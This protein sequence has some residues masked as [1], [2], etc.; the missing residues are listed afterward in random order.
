M[1]IPSIS[2]GFNENNLEQPLQRNSS[3]V[4][5]VV[6]KI[7]KTTSYV[8]HSIGSIVQSILSECIYVGSFGCYTLD[9][10]KNYLF[11]GKA[12]LE[13]DKQEPES[14]TTPVLKEP[15]E[16][17]SKLKRQG[18]KISVSPSYFERVRVGSDNKDSPYA[19]CFKGLSEIIKPPGDTQLQIP[20]VSEDVSLEEPVSLLEDSSI[21]K[22]LDNL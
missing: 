2:M 19:E 13:E 18:S 7:C 15:P 9:D 8:I 21:N 17:E 3:L 5:R 6:T 12:S 20:K 22:S 1:S 4:G 14:I 11:K 16:Y 10:L